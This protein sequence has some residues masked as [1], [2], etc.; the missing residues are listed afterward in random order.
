MLSSNGK[1]NAQPLA[2]VITPENNEIQPGPALHSTHPTNLLRSIKRSLQTTICSTR[3][4]ALSGLQR[5][6]LWG[7]KAVG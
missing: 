2:S 3:M 7:P 1:S 6:C 5:V 4:K